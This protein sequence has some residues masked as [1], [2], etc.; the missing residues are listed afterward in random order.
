MKSG[1]VVLA[2]LFLIMLFSC[3]PNTTN[4]Y[5][6]EV[7]SE[8]GPNQ[9]SISESFYFSTYLGG[10]DAKQSDDD[11]G[12]HSCIGPDG[13]V[14]SLVYSSTQYWPMVDA[15]YDTYRGGESDIVLVQTTADGTEYMFSTFLGGN[16]LEFP[17]KMHVDDQGSVYIVGSTSSTDLATPGSYDE[18]FNGGNNDVFVMKLNPHTGIIHYATYIGGSSDEHPYSLVVDSS[19]YVYVTGYTQSNDFPKVNAIDGVLNGGTDAFIFKLNADGSDLE[20]ST[21]F[22]GSGGD[23]GYDI[24]LGLDGKVCITG[25]TSSIDF[26][27]SDG[28]YDRTL[29]GTLDGF[30]AKI[31]ADGSEII[32]SSLI[33]GTGTDS[34]RCC[35][36][37]SAGNL[38][39]TGSTQ[40]GDF[41][42]VAPYDEDSNGNLDVFLLKMNEQGSEL[43][44]STYFGGNHDDEPR[45]ICLDE[46]GHV[47]IQG[48]TSSDDFP[49]KN[50]FDDE[51]DGEIDIDE[52]TFID[53]FVSRLDIISNRLLFSTYIGG[54][55]NEDSGWIDLDDKGNFVICG[56][57][58]SN[59]FPVTDD[60]LQAGYFYNWD[61]FVAAVYDR[62]D[63]DEDDLMEFQERA[64]GTDPLNPDSDS[65]SMPDGWEYHNGLN[66]LLDDSFQD[67]DLD[68]LSNKDEYLLGTYPNN[69]D[70]DRDSYPDE[71]EVANGFD[72]L[73]SNV[74]LNELLL[75]NSPLITAAAIIAVAALIVYLVRPK[76]EIAAEEQAR[77]QAEDI[78][79]TRRALQELTEDIQSESVTDAPVDGPMIVE[80]ADEGGDDE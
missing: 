59:D 28:A 78:E 61:V 52:N 49:M 6:F 62:G 16:G 65:D 32:Y 60:S 33:G 53:C 43:L 77:I 11:R 29:N 50:A 41:P 35:V 73:D 30:I 51:L 56:M 25:E 12:A 76:S 68:G 21:F 8:I 66:P 22:G 10:D 14:Y 74:P 44:Y 55:G 5:R 40:S 58:K 46:W 63:M 9:V 13:T 79:A 70:S 23:K 72:P 19:G 31:E 80:D 24:T 54:N 75:F 34:G 17:A 38:Y 48:G 47:V 4:G 20:F 69:P 36:S 2:S 15:I 27:S 57:T 42:C 26:S 64:L 7:E 67:L 37:D 18:T 45:G 39:V 71:W 3:L 1:R